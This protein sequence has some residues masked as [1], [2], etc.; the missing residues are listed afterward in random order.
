MFRRWSA[1]A[2]QK[3]GRGAGRGKKGRRPR[4]ENDVAVATTTMLNVDGGSNGFSRTHAH[5]H[6]NTHPRARART[7]VT[8]NPRSRRIVIPR[9][10]CFFLH[11]TIYGRR[12]EPRVRAS[13]PDDGHDGSGGATRYSLV[14]Q[15][16]ITR[17]ALTES[18]L[19]R[20]CRRQR[21]RWLY[22]RGGGSYSGRERGQRME[23]E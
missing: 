19:S 21:R 11:G 22:D 10:R 15:A 7:F 20:R 12:G 4:R 5:S 16:V 17:R 13:G 23:W 6:T 1:R 18:V 2:R 14:D 9:V 8:Q 3:E